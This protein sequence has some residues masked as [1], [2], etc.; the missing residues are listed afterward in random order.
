MADAL[1]LM[2]PSFLAS[3]GEVVLNNNIS[4][5]AQPLELIAANNKNC[6]VLESLIFPTPY[7]KGQRAI[8]VTGNI[9]EGNNITLSSVTMGTLQIFAKDITGVNEFKTTASPATAQEIAE[10]IAR[11][12]N[13]SIQFNRVYSANAF[14]G[15]G[16]VDIIAK[17]TGSSLNLGFGFVGGF[18]ALGGLPNGTDENR[19]QQQNN[20][21]AYTQIFGAPVSFGDVIDKTT[22]CLLS[23]SE[24]KYSSPNK[25]EF[26][27]TG[28][29]KDEFDIVEYL[30]SNQYNFN[31]IFGY[32]AL[33]GES[34]S[35]GSFR[36]KFLVGTTAVKYSFSAAFDTRDYSSSM[37]SIY[38]FQAGA[39]NKFFLT[40]SP[41]LKEVTLDSYEELSFIYK[42]APTLFR[43]AIPTITPIFRDGSIGTEQLIFF[44]GVTVGGIYGINVSPNNL[45]IASI[46]A[47]AGKKVR[48]YIIKLRLL[49]SAPTGPLITDI[50]LASVDKTYRI[51]EPCTKKPIAFI[52]RLG[53]VDTF[54]FIGDEISTLKRKITTGVK[55]IPCNTPSSINDATINRLIKS[56]DVDLVKSLSSGWI[57]E[58]VYIWL[59]ELAAS[60]QVWEVIDGENRAILV[61]GMTAREDSEN[62]KFFVEIEYIDSI[63]YKNLTN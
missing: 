32:V 10:D 41:D 48:D 58:N 21:G 26:D 56:A 37:M 55:A 25:F 36:R 49:T 28:A 61:T 15:G 33:W 29:L 47:A 20:Y 6:L 57:D 54:D 23:E 42:F 5:E 53:V 11:A 44:V 12:L 4:I 62:K 1:G 63:E 3:I 14:T 51:I 59:L 17:V 40:N 8:Q 50:P 60:P 45:P 46:E 52:N 7:V 22:F 16:R 34:Y 43:L 24:K 13:D 19:G 35:E 39:T 2:P 9:F 27:L 18:V 31:R 38:T 30:W